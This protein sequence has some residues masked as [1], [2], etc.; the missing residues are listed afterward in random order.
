MSLTDKTLS[1]LRYKTQLLINISLHSH[2]RKFHLSK[3]V[4]KI[5]LY[6]TGLM[7]QA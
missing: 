1:L 3:T 4:K 6:K 5:F 2:E 7:E